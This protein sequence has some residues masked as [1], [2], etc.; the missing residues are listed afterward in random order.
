M[1]FKQQKPGRRR[2]ILLTLLI[3]LLL[4]VAYTLTVPPRMVVQVNSGITTLFV[5]NH[6]DDT[7]ITPAQFG[8]EPERREKF[9]YTTFDGLKLKVVRVSAVD[10]LAGASPRG[11]IIFLHGVRRHKEQIYPMAA[12]F[13]AAGYDCYAPDLRSH[14]ESEGL[15]TTYGYY[16]KLDVSRLIDTISSRF[17]TG[18]QIILWGQSMGAATAILTMATDS[19]VT[20][21]IIES[22]FSDFRQV[23]ADYFVQELGFYSESIRDYM[24]WGSQ[25]LTGM[26]ASQVSPIIHSAEITAPML[27]VHGSADQRINIKYAREIFSHVKSPGSQFLQIDSARHT[28]IWETG[29]EAYFKKVLEFLQSSSAVPVLY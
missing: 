1:I 24:I 22:T 2:K 21:G 13:S 23:V 17:A 3:V 19:R 25:I 15:F 6:S 28:N 5:S 10:S 18:S 7:L 27:F 11:T 26:E 8:I 9:T 29:G 4:L 16:E 20:A 12:F 14:G